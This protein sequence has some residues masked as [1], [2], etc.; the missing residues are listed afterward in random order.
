MLLSLSQLHGWVP[1]MSEGNT[2][3]IEEDAGN[4]ISECLAS[5]PLVSW[6][7]LEKTQL[8]NAKMDFLSLSSSWLAVLACT[9]TKGSTSWHRW[10]W[11]LAQDNGSWSHTVPKKP[12]FPLV[13]LSFP[14]FY[15]VSLL[16]LHLKV[17]EHK[18]CKTQE[19]FPFCQFWELSLHTVTFGAWRAP[20]MA[21]MCV[22]LSMWRI[23]FLT[24]TGTDL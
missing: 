14:F 24:H 17:G 8:L 19:K 13:S 2:A 18:D 21:L 20:E 11:L 4:R 12:R 3:A 23:T 6:I 9:N 10:G 16:F 15:Y 7:P 22:F 5:P 1:Q